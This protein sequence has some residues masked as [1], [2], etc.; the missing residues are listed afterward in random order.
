MNSSFVMSV[1][2]HRKKYTLQNLKNFGKIDHKT[3]WWK[4]SKKFHKK[5]GDCK[6]I[7]WIKINYLLREKCPNTEFFLVCIFLHPGKYGPEKTPYLDT[8]HKVFSHS[9]INPLRFSDVFKVEK[10]C[11]GNEWVNP[12]QANFSLLYLLK[13]WEN[14]KLRAGTFSIL[15]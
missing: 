5:Y 15:Y 4:L 9:P 13:T 7:F 12:C 2:G 1:V 10:E 6:W 11:I 14:T 8:F 3:S